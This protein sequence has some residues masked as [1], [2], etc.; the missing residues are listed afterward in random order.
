M[1]MIKKRNSEEMIQRILDT[2]LELFRTKGYETTTILD[3]VNAMEVSRGAFYHHFKSKEEVLFALLERKAIGDESA[4]YADML[5]NE[6]LTGVEKLRRLFAYS[7]EDA[8]IGEDV[9]LATALLS[10]MK[11]PK[12]LAKQLKEIQET[13]WLEPIILAGIQDGSI[14][15]NNPRVLVELI[16]LLLNFWLFPTIFPGDDQ[17]AKTKVLMIKEVLDGLG[18]PLLDENLTQLLMKV[19]EEVEI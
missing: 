1:Q 13:D 2:S 17:Y 3:I 11:E 19:I 7:I 4:F 9:Y 16:F 10:L 12:I 14:E 15:D 6:T 5:T 8:F 18:C